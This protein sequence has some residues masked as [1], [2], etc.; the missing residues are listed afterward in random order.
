M[1]DNK[2]KYK[3]KT[4]SVFLAI[5]FVINVTIEII[6]NIKF[7]IKLKGLLMKSELIK[8]HVGNLINCY[9]KKEEISKNV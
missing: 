3:F 7:L 6:M 8:P 1:R 9:C 4:I 2:I 5:W